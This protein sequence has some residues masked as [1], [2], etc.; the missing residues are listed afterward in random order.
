MLKDI[1][2]EFDFRVA[3]KGDTVAGRF[4][5][6]SRAQIIKRLDQLGRL[7]GFTRQ[8]DMCL[9]TESDRHRYFKAFLEERYSVD[10]CGISAECP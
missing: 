6:G 7:M 5:G 2:E 9:Q 1:L 3:I 4:R 10:S 8:L